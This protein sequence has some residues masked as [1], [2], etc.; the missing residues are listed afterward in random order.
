M[1]SATSKLRGCSYVT[2]RAAVAHFML[3]EGHSADYENRF[4]SVETPS[5]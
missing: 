3:Q 2:T 1:G 5:S 4:I